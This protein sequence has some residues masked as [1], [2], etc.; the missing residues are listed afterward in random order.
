MQIKYLLDEN[1]L[2]RGLI[3]AVHRYDDQIDILQSGD[4]AAPHG[5]CWTPISWSGVRRMNGCL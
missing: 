1:I 5:G 3:P 2:H 4:P